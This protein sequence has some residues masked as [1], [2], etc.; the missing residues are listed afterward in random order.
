[1]IYYFDVIHSGI[2]LDTINYHNIFQNSHSD[3][4]F[5][6]SDLKIYIKI[7]FLGILSDLKNP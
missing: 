5:L 3:I 6:N 1:M 7:C 2:N 4:F